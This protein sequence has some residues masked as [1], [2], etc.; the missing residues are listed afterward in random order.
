MEC[1]LATLKV[2]SE[3]SRT[4]YERL[5]DHAPRIPAS[6]EG[7]ESSVL[8]NWQRAF[9]PNDSKAFETR[10]SW[11]GLDPSRVAMAIR[12]STSW[13]ELPDW[14][15]ILSE[16]LNPGANADDTPTALDRTWPFA[17]VLVPFVSCAR[18]RAGASARTSMSRGAWK[19]LEDN[20][21][22][23]LSSVAAMA[24]YQAFDARR[25]PEWRSTSG[26]ASAGD[27]LY[28]D[29]VRE[30]LGGGLCEFFLEYS[31]L[32]RQLC[33]LVLTWVES[34]RELTQRFEADR[35]RIASRFA[36]GRD[37]GSIDSLRP[38][39]SDRH[40][41]GR[42]VIALTLTSGVRL[43][44]KPRNIGVT[45]N[46]EAFLLW[47]SESGLQD[48]PV[49]LTVL[50]CD[51]YGWIEFIQQ[52]PVRST[53]EAGLYF[54]R[55]GALLCLAYVL[56]G[57]DLHMDNI[58]CAGLR[59]PMLIDVEAL[60][61]PS[62]E[63]P[64]Q[65]TFEKAR[66]VLQRSVIQSGLLSFQQTGADG[67]VFDMGGFCGCGG[68]LSTTENRVWKFVGT[69]AMH[70]VFEALTAEP[71]ENVLRLDG[72]ILSPSGFQGEITEGFE[73]AY[74]FLIEQRLELL[75]S[76][77]RLSGF[78]EETTRLIFRP[79]NLY[80]LVQ[81][82]LISP[83]Y[84]REGI[85]GTLLI[86]SLN[87]VFAGAPSRPK[88]WP[89]VADERRALEHLDI[90]LFTM[91]I[92]G[93]RIVS[94]AGETVD[95]YYRKSGFDVVTDRLRL[96]SEEDLRRQVDLIRAALAGRP[97]IV[98]SAVESS[99][100]DTSPLSKE[101]LVSSALRI[102]GVI[103]ERA[104]RGDDG[105]A[106][107]IAPAYLRLD[108]RTDE[109]V[110][111]YLYDGAAGISLFLA[112][113]ATVV[114]RPIDR[115]LALAA[116]RPIKLVME[117]EQPSR[118]LEQEGIGICNGLGSLVYS[119]TVVA[120]LLEEEKLIDLARRLAL[121]ISDAKIAK[122]RRLDLEGGAAGAIVALIE[123]FDVTGDRAVLAR[124]IACG[125]HL[126]RQELPPSRG[127]SWRG[128]ETGENSTALAGLAHGAAGFA[129]A[130]SRLSATTRNSQYLAAA[131]RA[132]EYERSL[133]SSAEGNWPVLTSDGESRFM[134]AWCHGA[135]GLALGRLGSLVAINGVEASAEID[136]A[137]RT[138][139][140]SGMSPIDHLCCGNAGRAEVLLTA[141]RRLGRPAL[142]FEAGKRMAAVVRRAEAR[143]SFSLRVSDEENRSFQPGF[144]RGCSGIGYQ[145]LRMAEPSLPS[146][147]SFEGVG[148]T[149]REV[150]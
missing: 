142:V 101:E 19:A 85:D 89:L 108:E 96:L 4:L 88:L 150:R 131:K 1:S 15:A 35:S 60:F 83:D 29:F 61:Q 79:S 10:L 98:S 135:P 94:E 58:I 91:T 125:E 33:Q 81:S 13:L 139:S 118:L 76:D 74:R 21:L 105:G 100:P 64:L 8:R 49:S 44:Y 113:L 107:W 72:E 111:Y 145:L 134:T 28:R 6:G 57:R 16:A 56:E 20:L 5:E 73:T 31:V 149:R 132:I 127:G 84:Q 147:L 27:T 99:V 110:S 26:D 53:A 129:W 36:S 43:I 24:L 115:E 39:L 114:H 148:R 22:V 117:S 48:A 87:R 3:R 78:A 97:E 82:K 55:A 34:V 54:R 112:A 123:L 104:I 68:H 69:D 42:Q 63:E 65:G 92:G 121:E 143:G 51:G 102:A 62:A 93:T 124:A 52:Q 66:E 128:E 30:M 7:A 59:G 23:Q 70:P 17:S 46:Y 45:E 146:I 14:T 25:N 47:L 109:G 116:L 119:L 141:G 136:Q 38:G 71:M 2:I 11:D 40:L 95:D 86:D 37:P 126:L 138:T 75:R 103:H 80:A 77:S 140:G 32:A 122:D 144:F 18:E 9:S 120:S 41:G 12:P 90:P 50:R 137:L 106:T 133:Y 67:K 130:L